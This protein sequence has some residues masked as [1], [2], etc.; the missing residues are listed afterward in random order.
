VP[1]ESAFD[2]ISGGRDPDHRRAAPWRLLVGVAA[3]VLIAG[4]IAFRLLSG[5][6]GPVPPPKPQASPSPVALAAPSMLHGTPLQPGGAPGTL[7]FL[8]GEELRLLNV[9]EQAPTSLSSIMPDAG[10]ARNPLGPDPAVQQIIS[11]AGGVVAL[12]YSH[13]PAG[14][15]DI[16]DVLFVPVDASG[17][18]PPR[19]ITRANYMALAPDHR[20]VWV[21]QAGPPWGNGPV[22]SPAWLVD[23]DGRRLSGVRRLNDQALVA[24]TVRGLL[25]QS[26]DEKLALMDPVNGRAEPAGIPA[27]A[28][29]AGTDAD[30]VAWQA[31]ACPLD[32]P[33]HVTDV[34]GGPD[35]QIALPPHTAVDSGDTSD[36]D[37]AGQRLVLPL[38]ITDQQGAITGTYV[39]VADLT[40]RKL[41]RV[42]GAPI[43]V[44]GLPAVLGAFP[45]GSSDVVCARWSA[46]G[47]GLWIV[48]TDGLYFQAGYWTGR[49]PLRVLQPQTG[50][51]YKFD[52]PGT[53]SPTA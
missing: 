1:D 27:N 37:P 29:I 34:G 4:G 28:I 20:D 14:L 49:G 33:L 9:R 36:F 48:A 39:Y 40:T 46:D 16:G 42:P 23:E 12:I 18:G 6:S 25:V 51:A 32:C 21:E 52:V 3:A 5:S 24:A 38:D 17:A 2:V 31:A 22:G 30:H 43:P 15:P 35:T 11:V 26:P 13:G 44:A 53:G 47:S 8:G 19:I 41:I 50:L 45:A 7:L 10:D